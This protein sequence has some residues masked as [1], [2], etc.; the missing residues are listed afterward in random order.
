MDSIGDGCFY[1]CFQLIE[2][3]EP[4]KIGTCGTGIFEGCYHLPLE[5]RFDRSSQPSHFL[6]YYGRISNKDLF[7]KDESFLI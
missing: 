7:P 1:D 3:N 2:I 6:E 5:L 4:I